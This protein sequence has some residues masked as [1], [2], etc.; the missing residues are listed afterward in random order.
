MPIGMNDRESEA[1]Q[2]LRGRVILVV[3]SPLSE[4][5]ARRFGLSRL[6][7]AGLVLQV[8]EVAP[9]TLPRAENQWTERPAGID[10]LRMSTV[11][12]LTAA[13]HEIEEDDT[14]ISLVGVFPGQIDRCRDV[15]V[16]ISATPAKLAGVSGRALWDGSMPDVETRAYERE[17]PR[18]VFAALKVKYWMVRVLKAAI[19]RVHMIPYFANRRRRRYGIRAL[20]IV[21]VATTNK[22][23]DPLFLD[24]QT[25]T[26]ALHAFDYDL[27]LDL[28]NSRLEDSATIAYVDWLGPLHPDIETLGMTLPFRSPEV[29]FGQ[30]RALFD[31]I[32][33]ALGMPVV[34]AAHPRATPGTLDEWYGNREVVYA[35][36]AEVMARS[37]LVLL[38][39]PSDSI[40]MVVALRKPVLV[41]GSMRDYRYEKDLKASL[42]R[43]LHCSRVLLEAPPVPLRMPVVDEA[44]YDGF[45]SQFI[46]GP[47]GDPSPFWD[48]VAMDLVRD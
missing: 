25:R 44:V 20:D 2:Q 35:G 18:G 33:D 45:F 17:W 37:R 43:L 34:V 32:E 10:V 28:E 14:I 12:A 1:K 29:H 26:R 6:L 38:S 11:A 24:A 13:C 40:A 21:W 8:W 30:L 7:E 3:E 39:Y 9:L 42:C 27:V 46:M 15:L 4:R 47:D 31:L 23:F 5:D 19:G 41:L 16:A 22:A 36:T 48:S